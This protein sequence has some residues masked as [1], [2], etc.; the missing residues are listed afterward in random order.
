MQRWIGYSNVITKRVY[1]YVERFHHY[2]VKSSVIPFEVERLNIGDA[3]NITTGIFTAPRPGVY[4]FSFNG[5]RQTDDI[6]TQIQLQVNGKTVS[7]AYNS[8]TATS[9]SLQ[10]TIKLNRQ[11]KVFLH[12]SWG[13]LFYLANHFTGFLL[14]EEHL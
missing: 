13:S 3:M 11:D 2:S 7:T 14:A 10:S 4:F 6:S 1:F 8:A 12:L 5:L 9:V